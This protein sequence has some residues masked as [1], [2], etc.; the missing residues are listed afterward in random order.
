MSEQKIFANGMKFSKPKAGAPDFVKGS[1]AIKIEEFETFMKLYAKKGWV[2]I[3]LKVSKGGKAYAELNTWTP[4][5]SQGSGGS[6][7][8]SGYETN[9]QD[10]F[11]N[12]GSFEDDIP[13]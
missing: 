10:T 12:G 9:N 1:L 8:D 3:D 5:S 6:G 11:Q 13:F 2:N 7:Y 4:D